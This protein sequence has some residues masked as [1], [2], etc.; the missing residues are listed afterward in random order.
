V[1][2]PSS[3]PERK[4]S[5][6]LVWLVALGGPLAVSAVALVFRSGT[7]PVNAALVLVLPVL[8]AALYGG[9]RGGIASAFG[10]AICF[11]FFFTRPYYSFTID[12]P[13]DVETMVVLLLVGVV[14]G[15]IVV[16]SRRSRAEASAS[17]RQIDQVHRVAEL[18]SGRSAPGRL[19][20]IV[21][22]EIAA[23]LDARAVRFE[24]PPYTTALLT[25]GHGVVN[26][27]GYSES[28]GLAFGPSHELCV[29]VWGQGREVGRLVV[30]LDH[31]A[32]H[33]ATSTDDRALVVAL[34]DQL[35]AVLAA[36]HS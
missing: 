17:R 3:G 35:G 30:G 36:T 33:L 34:A 27:P 6:L 24:R 31:D 28:D 4:P 8:A 32:T 2:P 13:N 1:H 21:S 9:R 18:A 26:V 20:D 23:L 14:V 16:R 10:A 19:V 7:F 5:G 25:L 12:D 11:D 29:S 22:R 15:E